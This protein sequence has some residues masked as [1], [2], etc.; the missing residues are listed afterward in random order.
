V[1]GPPRSPALSGTFPCPVDAKQLLPS[2]PGVD[3]PDA[4]KRAYSAKTLVATM[5]LADVVEVDGRRLR[6]AVAREALE[7]A[8]RPYEWKLKDD[9]SVDGAEFLLQLERAISTW[10]NGY[11]GV[12]IQEA[13]VEPEISNM[14]IVKSGHVVGRFY[15]FSRAKRSVVC[16]AAVDVVGPADFWAF[17]ENEVDLRGNATLQVTRRLTGDAVVAGIAAMRSPR[18]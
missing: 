16:V 9:V 1:I 17:G 11:D 18:E 14:S 13:R 2:K 10:N 7:E 3:A 15:L 6:P 8:L 12:L 4:E 5:T